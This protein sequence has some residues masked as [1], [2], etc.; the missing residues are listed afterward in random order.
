MMEALARCSTVGE[1]LA[2]DVPQDDGDEE[3]E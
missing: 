1:V 3:D 2:L